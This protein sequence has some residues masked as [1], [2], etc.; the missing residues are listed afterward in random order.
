MNNMDFLLKIVS[1]NVFT[2]FCL[3]IWYFE[4]ITIQVLAYYGCLK[5]RLT[6]F[7]I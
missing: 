4:S 3:F 1:I 7:L 6:K 5:T 2:V